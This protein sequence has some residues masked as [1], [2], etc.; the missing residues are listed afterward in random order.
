VIPLDT[1]AGKNN[2]GIAAVA[3]LAGVSYREAEHLFVTLCA[4]SEVT[5][6]WDRREV[7]DHLGLTVL[8][9]MH[10]KVKPNLMTWDRWCNDKY[11]QHLVSMTGHAV[12]V[13]NGLLYDQVYRCGIPPMYSPYKRKLIHSYMRLDNAHHHK[14]P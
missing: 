12:A 8:Q 14:P 1:P 2:C 10:Y 6:V 11:S 4:K 3:L 5:T 13:K 7:I 9:E